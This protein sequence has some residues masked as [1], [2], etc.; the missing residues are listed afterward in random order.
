MITLI[1]KLVC[2]YCAEYNKKPCI[3]LILQSVP[4]LGCKCLVNHPWYNFIQSQFIRVKYTDTCK[5]I[6]LGNLLHSWNG[7]PAVLYQDKGITCK[8]WYK[9]GRY[10]RIDG[11]AFECNDGV[12]WW[13]KNG[14]IHRDNGPAI[15]RPNGKLEWYKNGIKYIPDRNLSYRPF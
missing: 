12:E 10:H 9:L 3:K 5:Y 7:D 1:L 13:Y 2:E 15:V 4:Y 8:C 14:L 11:P 6:Y